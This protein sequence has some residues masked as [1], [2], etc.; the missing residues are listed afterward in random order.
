MRWL[1]ARWPGMLSHMETVNRCSAD[2]AWRDVRF[3]LDGVSPHLF[4][5][6][7]LP[8]FAL[9]CGHYPLC[10]TRGGPASTTMRVKRMKQR[11]ANGVWIGLKRKTLRAK[12]G[13]RRG[14][15]L[16]KLGRPLYGSRSLRR[17]R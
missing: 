6:K 11:L 7:L 5:E 15:K 16:N 10:G 13:P 8:Y 14:K 17:I 4:K 2:A 9:F 1:Y 3:R 12:R